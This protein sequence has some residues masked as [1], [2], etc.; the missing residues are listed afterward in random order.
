MM[1]TTILVS[2]FTLFYVDIVITFSRSDRLPPLRT[3]T[4]TFPFHPHSI[5]GF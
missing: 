4:H 2:I 5:E 3:Y 1:A